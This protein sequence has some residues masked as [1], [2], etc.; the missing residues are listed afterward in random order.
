MTSTSSGSVAG[1]PGSEG[2]LSPW[3]SVRVAL[4]SQINVFTA[5]LY[6]EA[7]TRHGQSFA[8]GYAAAGVE[9][10]VIVATIGVLFS[11]LSRT[12]PYGHSLLLFLGTGVFPIYL[13][14]HTSLRIRQP[15]NTLAHRNRFPIERPLD[16]LMVHAVLHVVSSAA[17][18]AL[19]FLGLYWFGGVEAAIPYD[20]LTAVTALSTLFLLG[21]A[22]GIF[23]AVIARVVPVWDIVWPAIARASL[24]FSGPYFVAAY[25]TPSH[26]F[27]F[28]LNPVMHGVN[29]F[30]HAFYP[31]Y[32]QAL[33]DHFYVLMVSLVLFTLG[34]L[35]ETGTR[36]YL[37]EKE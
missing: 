18:A 34:L 22:T 16:H 6:R 26:R 28:G 5:L 35:L 12:P 33:T 3:N 14:I 2:A 9:P 27:Y 17:V 36:R 10:L 13:F 37:E 1:Q 31:F 11:A 19:F 30:R 8:L 32:P 25:L 7:E 20:P 15:L 4:R 24:H 21:L 23:N 29:W